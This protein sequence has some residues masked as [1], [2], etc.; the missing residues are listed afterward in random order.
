MRIASTAVLLLALITQTIS[1]APKKVVSS[2]SYAVYSALFT[3][4][5][6]SWLSS[7]APLTISAKTRLSL[8]GCENR[9]NGAQRELFEKLVTI[10][11]RRLEIE[12]KFSLPS[13][14][15]HLIKKDIQMKTGEEPGLVWLS[16]VAFSD[17]GKHALVFIESYCGPLCATGGLW[18]LDQAAAG[19]RV[20]TKNAICGFIS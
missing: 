9:E 11:K 19:W 18:K 3:Q 14:S 10:N 2:E 17:D 5:Y 20:S 4:R 6:K 12:P 16:A 13:N 15:Y 8:T 7:K 1:E